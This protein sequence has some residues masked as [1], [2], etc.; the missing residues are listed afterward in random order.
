VKTVKIAL[1]FLIAMC[2]LSVSAN[3]QTY[4]NQFTGLGSSAL[5]LELGKAAVAR[6]TALKPS[7][8]SVCSWSTKN[9]GI[10]GTSNKIY[11]YDQAPGIK[12]T[13]NFW[14]VWYQDAACTAVPTKGTVAVWSYV[15]ED[16]AVGNRCV[17][18]TGTTAQECILVVPAAATG[19][20][21]D[22]AGANLITGQTDIKTALPAAIINT[23]NGVPFG[24]AGTDVRPE[25]SQFQ[26]YRSLQATTTSISSPTAGGASYAGL[27]LA[28]GNSTCETIAVTG[29]P[30]DGGE[31]S[32]GLGT[33]GSAGSVTAAE[34][35]LPG[36]T[37]PCTGSAGPSVMNVTP[38]GATPV[39][40]AV[41]NTNTS[42]FGNKT[43]VISNIQRAQLAEFLDGD[44]CR[45]ADL[46][47]TTATGTSTDFATTLIREPFSGTYT[48]TEYSVAAARSFQGSQ[49]AGIANPQTQP[50]VWSSCNGNGTR[51]RVT[52]T[53]NMVYAIQN[54]TDALGY[55]FWSTANGAAFTSSAG[56]P[57]NAKYLTVDGIDPLFAT[58]TNGCIPVAGETNG[59][60]ELAYVVFTHIKDG[61]YPIW[62]I[63]RLITTCTAG[64]TGCQQ[65]ESVALAAQAQK[66]ISSTL[67][68]FVPATAAS[69]HVFH[70][71]FLPLT[72][73]SLLGSIT[74][75]NGNCA[76]TEA[77]GDVGG[78]VYTTQS[79]I[80]YCA[81]FGV[82]NGITNLNSQGS[83]SGNGAPGQRD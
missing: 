45:P 4:S 43:N 81:D 76:A 31:G 69:L 37:D 21:T 42:G 36:G 18:R 56:V 2:S 38:V 27:G 1:C 47:P 3:A 77:G 51:S 33:F 10:S 8:Y 17:F 12:N 58:Y 26:I 44:L 15:Q 32:G 24:V 55:F 50:T 14:T 54:V 34:F 79:D 23:L 20:D 61:T 65:T 13:G 40:V 72:P 22:V 5:F 52:S 35:A 30:Y 9:S 41:N 78:T 48:T 62:S 60:C 59:H 66:E 75:A 73:S 74:V 39:V 29:G 7:G 16:S 71:H 57:G 11:A 25:D 70:S 83:S 49:E 67:P 82:T 64:T 46:F 63:Q 19:T 53:G 6:A 68:D 28:S 80:D